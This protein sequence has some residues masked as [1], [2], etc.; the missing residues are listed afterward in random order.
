MAK[1]KIYQGPIDSGLNGRL[2]A[3]PALVV[4]AFVPG[5]LLEQTASGYQT[6]T[7][8]ATVFDQPLLIAEEIPESEGG[9]I[10]TAYTVG[11]TIE[12]LALRSGEFAYML[13]ADAQA[14]TV[15]KT[16]L[17]SN[18]DGTLKIALTDG[19]EKILAYSEEVVTTSGVERVLVSKA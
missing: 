18:G 1:N 5:T 15:K 8:A 6:S 13:V 17:S 12:P 3:S 14:L 2:N 9:T 4:D 10:D 11:D 19:T 7:I 16:G